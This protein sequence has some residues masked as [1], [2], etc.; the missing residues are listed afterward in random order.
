M[1]V[2]ITKLKSRIEAFERNQRNYKCKFK[3]LQFFSYQCNTPY[4]RLSKANIELDRKVLAD[5]AV[6]DRA[7]FAAI[8]EHAKQAL[9]D[10]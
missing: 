5:I 9:T 8:A 3:S 4:E 1:A 2:E 7:A 6:H 10:A